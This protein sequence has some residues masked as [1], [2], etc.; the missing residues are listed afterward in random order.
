MISVEHLPQH[1]QE[2]QFH[3]GVAKSEVD[4]EGEIK[5]MFSKTVDG[6][7][8]R[9]KAVETDMSYEPHENILEIVPNPKM[10]V[11]GT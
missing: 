5:I 1:V 2:V 7:G 3:L 8:K 10:I 4:E 11:K 6:S 9:F